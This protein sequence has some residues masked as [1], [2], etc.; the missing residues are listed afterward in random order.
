M[1]DANDFI[2]VEQGRQL[3]R[4]LLKKRREKYV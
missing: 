2:V 3:Q 4:E 1:A